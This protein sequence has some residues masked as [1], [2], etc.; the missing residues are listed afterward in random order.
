MFRNLPLQLFIA[1]LLTLPACAQTSTAIV[2]A[3]LN[4][5]MTYQAMIDSATLCPAPGC[6][7]YATSPNAGKDLATIDPKAK[8]VTIYLGPF[9]YTIDHIVMRSGLRIIGM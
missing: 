4:T 6:T 9:T 5:G 7:I 8:A 2:Y 1:L 3:D